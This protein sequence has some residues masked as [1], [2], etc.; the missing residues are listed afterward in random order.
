MPRD[1]GGKYHALP[2]A[3]WN[4]TVVGAKLGVKVAVRT[5]FSPAASVVVYWKLQGREFSHRQCPSETMN[6]LDGQTNT[7]LGREDVFSWPTTRGCVVVTPAVVV[8][9]VVGVV[10]AAAPPAP[11]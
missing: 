5:T 7:V 3:G 6:R 11:G 10:T 4:V 9:R 8:A 2:S 1:V